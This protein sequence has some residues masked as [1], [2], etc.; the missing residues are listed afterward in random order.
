MIDLKG[1]RLLLTGGTTGIGR[2]ML[3]SFAGGG[4]RVVT[5]GRNADALDEACRA[6]GGETHGIAGDLAAGDPDGATRGSVVLVGGFDG[7]VTT[8]GLEWQRI[9]MSEINLIPSASFAK[10]DIDPEQAQVLE[11]VAPGKLRTQELI[12]HRFPLVEINCAIEVA[13]AKEETARSSSPSRSRSPTGASAALAVMGRGP[14][15]AG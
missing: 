2:A 7:G 8:I 15:D 9:Q 3:S 12:T 1:M 13:Q 4:A 6:A 10:H 14:R 11:L 5:I